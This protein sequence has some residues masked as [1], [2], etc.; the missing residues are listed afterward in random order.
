MTAPFF[1][2]IAAVMNTVSEIPYMNLFACGF[3]P[4]FNVLLPMMLAPFIV[5]LGLLLLLTVS[6]SRIPDRKNQLLVS[7][8]L[9]A[10]AIL[11]GL[12][13]SLFPGGIPDSVHLVCM[14]SGMLVVPLAVI[15]PGILWFWTDERKFIVRDTLMGAGLTLALGIAIAV[16]VI[17]AVEE[18][19]IVSAWSGILAVLAG[20][21]AGLPVAL[22]LVFSGLFL[23]SCTGYLIL[24]M[25]KHRAVSHP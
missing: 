14:V 7:G 21:P 18:Q 1:S 19:A 22:V 8:I 20:L 25:I 17:L 10:A 6:I 4:D 13:P 9:L 15:I 12:V 16:T 23:L 24:G 5:V 2:L 11:A 3:A